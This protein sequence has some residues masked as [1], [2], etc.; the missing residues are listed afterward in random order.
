MEEPFTLHTQL[1]ADLLAK[2][3]TRQAKIGVVGVGYVGS[4]LVEG[5]VSAEFQTSGFDLDAKKLEA[6]EHPLFQGAAAAADL[7]GCDIICVCVPTPLDGAGKP[8]LV[9]LLSAVESVKDLRSSGKLI[10]IE[11]TVAPGT[12]RG[13]IEPLLSQAGWQVGVD[14]LLAI[15]PERIDPGNKD[16]KIGNTPKVVGGMDEASTQVAAEF[17]ASFV[18]KVVTVS[19]PEAAEMAKILENTFRLVNISLVNEMKDYADSLGVDIWE[20]IDAAATKPYAF[21]PH[22]P[23]PGVGGHCIPVDPVYL[24][25]DARKRSLNLN[26]VEA[27][28]SINENQPKKVVAEAKKKLEGRRNGHTPRLLIVGLSYK[29][30]TSDT[31]ESASLKIWEEAEKEGFEVSYSDPYVP[32]QNGQSSVWL[33]PEVLKQQDVVV[34]ATNHSSIQYEMFL[35][36]DVP[37]VDTRNS[38]RKYFQSQLIKLEEKIR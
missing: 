31:R 30:D 8:D 28:V 21:L 20:V 23:G 29:P 25:E 37:I 34:I 16:F 13:V 17:Y 7:E 19:T 10:V 33:T 5:I 36:L 38:L 32:S 15:S 35:G 26:L 14:L 1:Y 4:A 27:A 6:I 12:L 9:P 18:E 11:S 24:L 2:I 3:K 22:Y